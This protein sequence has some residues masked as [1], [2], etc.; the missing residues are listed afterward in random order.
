MLLAPELAGNA[1]L[2]ADFQARFPAMLSPGNFEEV[3]ARH[4]LQTVLG[5]VPG[6][7][8]NAALVRACGA[9]LGYARATQQGRMPGDGAAGTQI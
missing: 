4:E 3:A 8:N 7:L 2:M 9:V 1:A 6:T 5:E